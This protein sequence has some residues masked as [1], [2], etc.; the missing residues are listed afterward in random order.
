MGTRHLIEVKNKSGELKVAQYCQWDGYPTGAGSRI[1][2][3]LKKEGNIEK[4]NES[5]KKVD[6]FS[7]EKWDEM[8]E[9]YNN[10]DKET[11][12]YVDEFISRD[13][14]VD[15]LDNLIESDKKEILLQN[16]SDFKKDTL[17]C[18]WYYLID[19]KTKKL[20]IWNEIFDFN[21]LPSD[22]QLKNIEKDK[23]E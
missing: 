19:L 14:S 15:L 4:L 23:Y 5:L 8:V 7:D 10:K 11:R 13:L 12:I 6:F 20:H 21:N 22:N 16:N 18:E 1:V 3:F 17:F 2:N 9:K